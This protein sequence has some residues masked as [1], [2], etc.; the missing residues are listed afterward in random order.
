M[1]ELDIDLVNVLHSIESNMPVEE[2]LESMELEDS[3]DD[4]S[5]LLPT[6]EKSLENMSILE[7]DSD[8]ESAVSI[9]ALLKSFG[10][11]KNKVPPLLTRH[12]PPAI[13]RDDDPSKIREILDDVLLKMGYEADPNKG[14]NRILCGPDNKIGKCLLNLLNADKKYRVFLPE[15]PLLH[16]R[17]SKI[18]ILFSSYGDAGLIQLLRVMRNEDQEEWAKLISIQHID[19]ATKHVRRLALSLHLA[20]LISFLDYI[21]PEEKQAFVDDMESGDSAEV[22][23]KWALKFQEYLA[24]GSSRNA[25]FSLHMDMMRHCDDV[26]AISLSERLGGKDGYGLLLA[27]VKNSLLFSF[28]NNASAYAPYCVRL[29][30]C[31]YSAGYFHRCLKEE[32]FS[33]PFKGSSRNFACD[34]KREMDHLDALKGFRSGSTVN[35]ATCRMSLID[36]LN[37][38]KSQPESDIQEED[39]DKLG[40]EL[41]EIDL[42]HIFP[43]TALILKRQGI[44]LEESNVPYNVYSSTPLVLPSSILDTCSEDV[45]KYL[46]LRYLRKEG[47]FGLKVSDLPKDEFLHGP[48]ELVARA[49]RSKGVTMKRVI[50]S[51]VKAVRTESQAKED[52]RQKEVSKETKV[53]NCF[54]SENNAC[55]AL[56]NAD[57]K[58]PKVMKSLG[59]PRALKSLVQT[60]GKGECLDKYIAL[61]LPQLPKNVT[62]SVKLC[63]IEFAGTKFKMGNA[64]SGQEYLENI[65]KMLNT[66]INRSNNISNIVICEE[67]YSYTPDDFKAG[68]REQRKRKKEN[69]VSHLISHERIISKDKLNKDSIT[70]TEIGKRLISTY[71]AKNVAKLTLNRNVSVIVDSEFITKTDCDCTDI[72]ECVKYCVPIFC[73]TKTEPVRSTTTKTLN[74]KQRKGEAEMAVSDWLIGLQGELKDGDSVVC[75][76]TSGDIDAVYIHLDVVS[77]LWAKDENNEYKVP[78]YVVLQKQGGNVDVYNITSL[79]TLFEKHYRDL[80][81]GSKLAY[82]LCIGG[83]DFVPKLYTKSHDTVCKS[84]LENSYFRNSLYLIN[85]GRFTLNCDIFIELIKYMYTH[86]RKQGKATP[87]EEVRAISIAKTEDPTKPS[88]FRHA[89]PR[90]WLPPQSAIARLAEL[91]QLQIEYLQTAGNHSSDMPNFLGVSCLREN[92]SGE[93][94]YDFGNEAHFENLA[95]LPSVVKKKKRSMK[96]TPQGGAR[97]K[98]NKP[99]TSTPRK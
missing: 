99:M 37:V 20:F 52:T 40:W 64:K 21:E 92:R 4:E 19:M 57:S 80:A 88:G 39:N 9:Q 89:D 18:N 78:V 67:K 72:C 71:V 23:S 77:R 49:K 25:T 38:T 48:T 47:L 94:V 82:T 79:L 2:E 27:A 46:L 61:N 58:K 62:S 81:I 44:S 41:T 24:Y 84:V 63:T 28:V 34:T 86:K 31:H 22:S 10:F 12:P 95:E 17:K 45:G 56:L 93:I 60:C 14:V 74:V 6:L 13:G 83:N 33:T 76:V 35:S 30:C 15:F 69:D 7:E 70:Q 26:I 96:G 54:S 75:L 59:I 5:Q 42:N 90:K 51:T 43:A 73:E 8:E 3:T 87:F 98:R 50:K 1:S 91:V 97:K 16:L 85:D 32:L 68:T 11:T 66:L 55:Q 36:S 53:V 29:L 65:Q